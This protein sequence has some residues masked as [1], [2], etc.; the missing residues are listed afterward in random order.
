LCSDAWGTCNP[1]AA[2][3]A[4]GEGGALAVLV[5]MEQY[6]SYVKEHA[7]GGANDDQEDEPKCGGRSESSS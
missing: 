6:Q 4:A 7:L 3:Y 2:L 5:G 1:K